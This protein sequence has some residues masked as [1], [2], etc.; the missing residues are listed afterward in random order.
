MVY[1]GGGLSPVSDGLLIVQLLVGRKTLLFIQFGVGARFGVA[2]RLRW[3]HVDVNI[4]Q[5]C[6][7]GFVDWTRVRAGNLRLGRVLHDDVRVL[8]RIGVGGGRQVDLGVLLVLGADEVAG[9]RGVVGVAEQQRR[10]HG[11]LPACPDDGRL[12]H[13]GLLQRALS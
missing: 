6:V 1:I 4:S 13:E 7:S 11:G 10:V 5:F 12:L 2:I 9:L 3:R 8:S